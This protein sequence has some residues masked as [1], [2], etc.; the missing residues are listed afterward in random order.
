[1]F[2]DFTAV[3]VAEAARK[4]IVCLIHILR[5]TK[6]ISGDTLAAPKRV[7]VTFTPEQWR[8]IESLKG[9]MG[10][11]DAA[12]VRT[13]VISWLIEKGFALQAIKNRA[14][15]KTGHQRTS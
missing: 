13:I 4:S 6:T 2:I 10:R 14:R 1:M 8:I 12:A 3:W 5:D 15:K 9:E 7:L 11:G